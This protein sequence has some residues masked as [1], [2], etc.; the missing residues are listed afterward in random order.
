MMPEKQQEM[1]A[2]PQEVEDAAMKAVA[3]QVQN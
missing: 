2:S 1:R 3:D